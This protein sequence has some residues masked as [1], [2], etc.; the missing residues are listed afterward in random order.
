[1]K[2]KPGEHTYHAAAEWHGDQNTKCIDSH[3]RLP[4]DP[5]TVHAIELGWTS[6]PIETVYTHGT[7]V[8]LC[9]THVRVLYPMRFKAN[10]PDVCEKC[11]EEFEQR[12]EARP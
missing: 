10:E 11:V 7:A 3:E 2:L 5:G 8:A 6:R 1:M 4:E 9:G 12:T